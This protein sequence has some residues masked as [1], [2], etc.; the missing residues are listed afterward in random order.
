LDL[1]AILGGLTG[2]GG[3]PGGFDIGSL[4]GGLGNLGGAPGANADINTVVAGYKDVESKL[5]VLDTAVKALGNSTSATAAQDLITKAQAVTAAL[6][7]ATAKI[8]AA[9]AI[10]DLF[11]STE[12]SAPGDAVSA[13]L[14][15][16]VN[17]LIEKKAALVKAGQG[18]AILKELKDQKTATAAFTSAINSK[19]PAI[20]QI[21]A[22]GTSQRPITI[23]DK[24]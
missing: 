22:G 12:L 15:T 13:L 3:A 23:L 6:N 21:V 10:S 11:A 5:T 18:A 19:L 1:G 16:T 7:G 14:E 9:K 8:T 17:D 2:G 4:L 24:G 20:A